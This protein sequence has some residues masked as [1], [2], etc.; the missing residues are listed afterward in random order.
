MFSIQF[1]HY[2][3][4]RLLTEK[5]IYMQKY[6]NNKRQKTNGRNS[7]DGDTFFERR[8]HQGMSLPI[9][10]H[11]LFVIRK[12]TMGSVTAPQARPMS[13]TMEA[14]K[15]VIC[16]AGQGEIGVKNTKLQHPFIHVQ[17]THT[18][19]ITL[20]ERLR[21]GR[22]AG[23]RLWRWRPPPLARRRWR[24]TTYCIVATSGSSRSVPKEGDKGGEK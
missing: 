6:G 20:P 2:C 19:I 9:L 22:F 15:A 18:H 3:S 10:V 21:A 1:C 5:Q 13:S 14:W 12:P 16:R 8:T 7:D 17:E 4:A 24:N 11:L 23:R